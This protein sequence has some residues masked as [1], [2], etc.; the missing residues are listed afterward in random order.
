[1]PVRLAISAIDSVVKGQPPESCQWEIELATGQRVL[2]TKL[3]DTFADS[4]AFGEE[5]EK[6]I[7]WYLEKY[8]T[9]PFDT[10]KADFAAEALLAYGRDLAA[11]LVQ[12]GLLPTQGDIELEIKGRNRQV[13]TAAGNTLPRREG[14]DLQQLHWEVLEDITVWPPGYN[15]DSV[16]IFRSVRQMNGSVS[17]SNNLPT[18]NVFRILLVVSRPGQ[19]KDLDY[20]L[21]SRCLVAIIDHMSQ[22]VS[23]PKV[24]L[25]ILR[26]PT[27]Q[28][29]REHLQEYHYDL[30][31]LDMHGKVRVG[32]EGSATYV[33]TI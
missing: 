15:F 17:S 10:T 8:I 12:S 1:M 29:F 16:S 33:P 2:R 31:H 7:K 13:A 3:S 24:I 22:P 30:V 28:A 18:A 27:W 32:P 19:D 25:K 26:P 9:E 14:R 6:A 11:Q 23:G 21:V 4:T 20:Q 5:P